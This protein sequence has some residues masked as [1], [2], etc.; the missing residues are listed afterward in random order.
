MYDDGTVDGMEGNV[1]S[2]NRV[3]RCYYNVYAGYDAVDTTITDNVVECSPEMVDYFPGQTFTD[4]PV[5]LDNGYGIRVTGDG[6]VSDGTFGGQLV[7]QNSVSNCK[8]GI[9]LNTFDVTVESNAVYSNVTGIEVDD[10]LHAVTGNEIHQNSICLN[11]TGMRNVSTGTT[12]DAEDNWW[13]DASGPEDLQDKPGEDTEVPPCDSVTG[14]SMMNTDGIGDVVTGTV[15]Y[16]PWLGTDPNDLD[17]DGL[18]T[19]EE[20]TLGTDPTDPDTDNDGFTDGEE[21]AAGTDPLDRDDFPSVPV[22]GTTTP[23]NPLRL[24]GALGGLTLVALVG[25]AALVWRRR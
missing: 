17:G 15:D 13:G 21:V 10:Y 20:V 5:E 12:V 2:G 3:E 11:T 16:C 1:I 19:C 7:G 14:A 8:L 25:S 4:P 23:S 18:G 6:Q 9:L 22:G 24:I